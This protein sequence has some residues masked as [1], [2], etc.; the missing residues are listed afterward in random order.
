[1]ETKYEI[2]SKGIPLHI[3][4]DPVLHHIFVRPGW[5]RGA[6]LHQVAVAIE[7]GARGDRAATVESLGLVDFHTRRR[8]AGRRAEVRVGPAGRGVPI[9][10]TLAVSRWS[11]DR[12]HRSRS[13]W[14][15]CSASVVEIGQSPY[16]LVALGLLLY[17][18]GLSG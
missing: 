13:R 3:I 16:P 1:M 11:C 12:A 7:E 10:L 15:G 14:S 2:L 4:I 9:R 18:I 8:G 17:P 6:S 5:P